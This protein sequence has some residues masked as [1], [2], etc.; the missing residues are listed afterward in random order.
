MEPPREND[1]Q[2]EPQVDRERGMAAAR[3]FRGGEVIRPEQHGRPGAWLGRRSRGAAPWY[4]GLHVPT[5]QSQDESRWDRRD[6]RADSGNGGAGG[7][8]GRL[9]AVCRHPSSV[10]ASSSS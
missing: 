8:G 6:R 3:E 7:I 10:V 9:L 1:V 4:G 5:D 2:A